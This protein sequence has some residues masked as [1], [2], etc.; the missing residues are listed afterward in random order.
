MRVSGGYIRVEPVRELWLLTLGINH[1]P[2]VGNDLRLIW[3]LGLN[4]NPFR[5]PDSLD[6][7]GAMQ[8]KN[9]DQR[10][11][12]IQH[13]RSLSA[14][15]DGLSSR[16]LASATRQPADKPSRS[17]PSSGQELGRPRDRP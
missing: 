15:L 14:T 4:R 8:A 9:A 7:Q 16:A 10:N 12:A 2:G 5:V 3:P 11:V 13:C 1:E 6:V 17:S